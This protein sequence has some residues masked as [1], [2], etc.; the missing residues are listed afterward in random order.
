[1]KNARILPLL[2]VA[3]LCAGCPSRAPAPDETPAPESSGDSAPAAPSPAPTAAPTP[4]AVP[5][6]PRVPDDGIAKPIP[7]TVHPGDTLQLPVYGKCEIVDTVDC[8]QTDHRFADYPAGASRIETILGKPCR[9]LDVQPETASWV[10]WRLGEGKDLRPNGA[11]VVVIEYPDDEPRAFHVRNYGNNSRR[12]FYTGQS[13]GDAF[14]GPIVHH[15]PES[16]KIPQ[17]GKFQMWSSLTFLGLRAATRDDTGKMDIATDGFE[18][19]ISQYQKKWH[20]LS[21]GIAVSRILL[22]EI[23]DEKAAWAKINFPPAPLPRRHIFWREE[24][25]DGVTAEGGLCDS[26]QGL[27]WIEQKFRAMKIFAQNT[28]CKDLLE[29]G[30]NQGWDVNWKRR[31]NLPG[32]KH[33]NWMW[34]GKGQDWDIWGRIVPMAVDQYG[35]DV[36]PYY[37]YGGAAGDMS[38]S[39][40]PLGPQKRAE[41]LDMDNKPKDHGINYTH[42]WWSDGKLRVDITDPDTLDELEY[43]LDCTIFRFKEQVE[44]GGFLGV[45]MRPRP[46][47]WPVSFADATR[48]RFAKEE[49]G[50]QAVSRKDL[51][52]NKALYDRYIA[53]F[54]KR[55]AKFM[56]D[57]RKYLEDGGVKNAVAILENDDS[58]TGYPLKDGG[59]M[60]TDDLPFCQAALP[61]KNIVDVNDPSVVGQHRYL[62]ALRTPSGTWGCWEWQ[63]ASPFCDPEHYQKLK[64]VWIAMPFHALFTVTDP[65]CLKEFDNANGTST[66]IRH[67]D[68]NE[69]TLFQGD[70]P[71]STGYCMA[72]WEHAGRACMIAEVN[73]M[74]N[75]DPVNIGYLMGSNYT[76]GFPGP[77]VEFNRN[78]L[79]LPAL[80]S[81]K[82][83][84]ACADPDVTFRRIDCGGL[85]KGA[86]YA[87]VHTGRSPKSN[88]EIRV[89]E[90]VARLTDINGQPYPVREGVV[91]IPLLRPWQL[92]TFWA[93]R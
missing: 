41:P 32:A 11:Y 60:T 75:G 8:T 55:R 12:S 44:K 83:E 86:Y 5:A 1:M 47:Q 54:G 91:T 39:T 88:V 68:L 10:D 33:A 31:N 76:R 23:V 37:E 27:D 72:D 40:P 16:L 73:A 58:E 80:P 35:F 56:D 64:N 53:W 43:I 29:F 71:G 9:V 38:C 7:A 92:M 77:V 22:C 36:L 81:K 49:N 89:P 14:E 28:Y 18:I 87:V 82:L 42:I 2:A 93:A 67:Y 6:P 69:G 45:L 34:G 62:Q 85:G 46:G 51:K 90:G 70:K 21:A 61:G 66:I 20:P 30:H 63:H 50:G 19:A 59:S 52:S 15:K 4:A 25:A 84:G 65:A 26:N 48:A 3:A 57:I 13:N 78:F 17:T 74:A 24:M 79:A